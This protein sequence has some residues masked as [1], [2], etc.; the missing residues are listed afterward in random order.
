MPPLAQVFSVFPPTVRVV[1]GVLSVL[2]SVRY[3]AALNPTALSGR[4]DDDGAFLL[5]ASEAAS[6]TLLPAAAFAILMESCP[7]SA[8]RARRARRARRAAHKPSWKTRAQH[9]SRICCLLPCAGGL[10]AFAAHPFLSVSLFSFLFFFSK[11]SYLTH[12]D[13]PLF[14]VLV[15]AQVPA[16]TWAKLTTERAQCAAKFD[17]LGRWTPAPTAGR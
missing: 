5:C 4:D 1:A 15:S 12:K 17:D 13:T 9:L 10:C 8:V 2:L 14:L 6:L 3:A 7:T 11:Y 16:T